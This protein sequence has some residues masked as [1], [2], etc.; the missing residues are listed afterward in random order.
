[1][2]TYLQPRLRKTPFGDLPAP[3]A[4]RYVRATFVRPAQSEELDRPPY[5]IFSLRAAIDGLGDASAANPQVAR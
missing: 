2:Q 5:E 3:S 1:M 4:S